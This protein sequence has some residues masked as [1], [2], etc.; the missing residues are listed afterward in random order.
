MKIKFLSILFFCSISLFSQHTIEGIIVDDQSIPVQQTNIHLESRGLHTLSDAKG[1]FR[2]DNLNAGEY[3]MHISKAGYQTQTLDLKVPLE[4]P[5]QQIVLLQAVIEMNEIII[6]AP[7]HKRQRDHIMKV[8]R[9]ETAAFQ[10]QGSVTL[11]E[12]ITDFDGVRRVS[13]GAGIGKPVIRGLRGSRILTYTQ[14]MRLENQ[15]SGDDHDLGLQEAGIESVEVIK[16]PASLLYG[17][18]ALSGTLYFNPERFAAPK[19]S[20]TNFNSRY[21][22][23]TEGLSTSL[24]T[25]WSGDQFKFLARAT[26]V[27]HADYQTPSYRLS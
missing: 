15:Q 12:G 27:A 13:T 17:S 23:N 7:F 25:K 2:L 6:S 10:K 5:M 19:Q 24:G 22:S 9:L 18:D 20:E 11:S 26:R 16:G 21:F 4:K 1:I 3:V 8:E 14:G